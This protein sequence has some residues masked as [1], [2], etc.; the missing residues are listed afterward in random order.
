MDGKRTTLAAVGLVT[1]IFI[2]LLAWGLRDSASL[3]SAAIR[4]SSD[5]QHHPALPPRSI[6]LAFFLP[7]GRKPVPVDVTHLSTVSELAREAVAELAL[8]AKLGRAVTAADV[9]VFV[10]SREDALQIVAGG[11]ASAHGAALGALDPFDFSTFDS[12]DLGKG[13]CLLLELVE[14][15]PV[16]LASA[17]PALTV[18][19]CALPA[20]R[21]D[22]TW[23]INSVIPSAQ[24]Y[25]K[26]ERDVCPSI[27][28]SLERIWADI[29]ALFPSAMSRFVVNIG[30][31]DGVGADPLYPLLLAVPDIGGVF[32]EPSNE[33]FP[34]MS[35]HY[36]SRFPNAQ[37]IHAGIDIFNA[38][39][40]AKGTRRE[41][42][43]YPSAASGLDV[44]KLDIDSCECQILEILMQDPFFAHAKIIQIETNH[45]LPPPLLW[46]DMCYDGHHGR[47]GNS[48]DVWGCSAQ[49]AYEIV[50]GAG[51]E[52][53]QYDWPDAVF[54]H[55]NFSRSVFPCIMDGHADAH[56]LFLR[57]YWIG[58]QHARLVYSRFPGH[59]NNRAFVAALPDFANAAFHDPI[60][61][62]V[63]LKETFKGTLI[64]RPLWVEVGVAGT[65]IF[66][67]ITTTPEG[68]VILSIHA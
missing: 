50:K 29:N 7:L 28:L 34:R 27:F 15:V 63:Q 30:A 46:R 19:R 52:L 57:N 12:N 53:L 22:A 3:D 68:E 17:S 66:G 25:C 65:G 61:A 5:M 45:H 11:A 14:A 41:G 67:N 56:S 42:S 37:L 1:L 59:Q 8:P 6:V 38:V 64:K 23:P 26:E 4:H 62:L 51:F 60:A 13:S 36:R 49:S 55:R 10:I 31:K 40:L 24:G 33:D 18:S 20:N 43:P 58:L 54:V 32:I 44:L 39:E 2:N 47:S 35:E 48:L 16:I 9:S 21:K